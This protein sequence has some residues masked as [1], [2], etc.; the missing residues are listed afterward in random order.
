MSSSRR[1]RGLITM[2]DKIDYERELFSTFVEGAPDMR[3]SMD[4]FIK[5]DLYEE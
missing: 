2:V 4:V 5:G 1:L 3:S